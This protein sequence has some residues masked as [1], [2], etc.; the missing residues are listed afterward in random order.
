[1]CARTRL[2]GNDT[3]LPV[4]PRLIVLDLVMPRMTGWEFLDLVRADAGW[5]KVPI[6]LHTSMNDDY[7]PADVPALR[8]GVSDD[9]ILLAVG[10]GPT[11]G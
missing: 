1:L 9:E 2:I 11:R 6:V 5:K 10:H 8:K 3:S 7:R 4:T